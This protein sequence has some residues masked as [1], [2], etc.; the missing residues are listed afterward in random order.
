MDSYTEDTLKRLTGLLR[1]TATAYNSY[2]EQNAYSGAKLKDEA[3]WS[4][5]YLLES[6]KLANLFLSPT[7]ESLKEETT[8]AG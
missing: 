2:K 6:G 8:E 3:E 5:A 1:E 7:G 4:A